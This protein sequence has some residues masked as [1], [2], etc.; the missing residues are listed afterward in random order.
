M[1][2]GYLPEVYPDELFYSWVSRTFVHSGHALHNAVLR[3]FFCKRSDNPSKEFLG[4]LNED[5]KNVIQKVI[6]LRELILQHT[7][8]PQLENTAQHICYWEG[9]E[10]QLGRA[11]YFN[12]TFVETRKAKTT[13]L[14]S[15]ESR[16][17]GKAILLLQGSFLGTEK[18]SLQRLTDV[19]EA[20]EGWSYT[21]PEGGTVTQLRYA[22]PEGAEQLQ[23]L[24]RDGS[25]TLQQVPFTRTGSYAVF[26][27]EEGVTA[28]YVTVPIQ[29]S[30]QT[31]WIIA[32][33]AA[34]VLLIAVGIMLSRRKKKKAK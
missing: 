5:A 4:N 28:F 23:I 25:G 11:Q 34:A 13:V 27:L 2:I 14:E 24:A 33:S 10:A 19:P 22:I 1:S 30:W 6:P 29:E 31:Q 7:M 17:N 18:F 8:V 15:T 12:R 9:L 20:L 21:V 32:V 16:D 26:S 3:E